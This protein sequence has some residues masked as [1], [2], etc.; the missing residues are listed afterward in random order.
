MQV[1]RL[2]AG[3]QPMATYHDYTDKRTTRL[4]RVGCSCS[5][6]KHMHKMRCAIFLEQSEW[7]SGTCCMRQ[8]VQH[9]HVPKHETSQRHVI[10]NCQCDRTSSCVSRHSRQTKQPLPNEAFYAAV[11]IF[12]LQQQN[13]GAREQ[14]VS[15]FLLA[16]FLTLKAGRIHA[17]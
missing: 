11:Q 12:R 4:C 14:S 13:H 10:V 6:L 5:K 7:P 16:A 3:N 9:A 2:A 8:S 15:C 17:G 1:Q